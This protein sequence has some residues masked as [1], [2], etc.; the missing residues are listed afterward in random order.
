MSQEYP[1]PP[2]STSQTPSSQL[3]G[4]RGIRLILLTAWAAL[5]AAALGF[6]FYLGT[7]SP[8]A[9]EWEFVPAVTGHDP[10]GP[11]LWAQHNEHRLPLPRLVY[12]A[13]FRLTHDFRAGMVLQVAM[14]SGLG[15]WLMNLAARFRGRP[16]WADVFFP[17]SL[18]HVGHWENYL[19]GYQI[20]FALLIVLVTAL[21]VVA[22]RTTAE[23]AFRSGVIAGALTVLL[24][25]CGGSGVVVAVPVAGWLAY[26][27]ASVWRGGSK[28]R[29][30]VLAALAAFPVAYLAVYLDGYHRPAHHPPLGDGGVG[31]ALVTG[32]T[33]AVA[34]GAG[35]RGEWRTMLAGMLLLGGITLAAV[36]RNLKSPA[37]RPAAVGLIAVVAGVAGVALVIGL[38]RAG[39]GP[40]MGLASRYA[41]LTWPL[42]GI[43]YLFWVRRGGWGGRWVPIGLCVAA[44]LAFPSNT[45]YGLGMGSHV[46]SVLAGVEADARAG[47]P[48]ELIVRRFPDSLQAYQEERGIRAI[49]MLREAG[50]GAFAGPGTAGDPDPWW[51][52]GGAVALVLA[53]IAVRWLGRLGRAVQV[54]RA[55]ELFRLQHERFEQ[56]LLT[57]AAATGKPRGLTWA[58]CEV[59]GD[60][61]LAR[62]SVGGIVALVPVVIR[63]EPVAG[64]DME[65]VP[66]ARELRRATA[67]FTFNSGHWHTDGRV[68]F[69]LDPRQAAAHFGKHLTVIEPHH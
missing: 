69:N 34:F 29:G 30:L 14:L 16:H 48:P 42:L 56:M 12:F 21:G 31:V 51:I 2:P 32:E 9:D 36:S 58:G 43:A 40:K 37:T 5:T 67:V 59:V 46:R 33:L 41:F 20:C 45:G 50:V 3:V 19:I 28:W 15:L 25:L 47:L 57:A 64:S 63:F 27:A 38:G 18:L 68:V 23:T 26:L 10:L 8:S 4:E 53:A 11:W 7:N 35:I 52:A 39:L 1:P 62:D 13:L 44:A 17:I 61:V 65:D 55:R 54:E 6:V 24:V 66:A 60:A 49:P 22:L